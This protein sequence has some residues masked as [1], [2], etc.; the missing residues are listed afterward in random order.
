MREILDLLPQNREI[1]TLVF[2]LVVTISTVVYAIL[3]WRLTAETIKMRK[4]QTEPKISI[5][6][7]P[8]QAAFSF[9]DL[10]I[11][12]IGAGPAYEIKFIIL[13]EFNIKE[14][15]K[16]SEMDFIKEGITYMPPGYN[17]KSYFFGILGQY[18][19][20]IDKSLKIKAIYK[21]S[22]RKEIFEVIEINMSQFKGRQ[23]L[24]E[25]PINGIAKNIENI[26][27]DIH[28]MTSGF[29]RLRIDAY[30][31]KDREKEKIMREKERRE[32]QQYP[33]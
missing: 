9:F 7:Q 15:R 18:K 31:T 23:Q 26:Q 28:N 22:E 32:L 1:L 29:H 33:K 12:N 25:D 24:G 5:Y 11:K 13:K 17:I 14:G 21:N 4:A 8:C 2:S 10:V 20:V 6:L 19:E 27:K 16:L 30:T 3:T